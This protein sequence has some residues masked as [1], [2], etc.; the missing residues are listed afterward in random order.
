L[1]GPAGANEAEPS[2]L[3]GLSLQHLA[4][5]IQTAK[6]VRAWREQKEAALQTISRLQE[7]I[8]RAEAEAFEKEDQAMKLEEEA[9]RLEQQGAADEVRSVSGSQC[10]TIGT[11][12]IH[13][14]QLCRR[15]ICCQLNS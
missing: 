2:R 7:D 1:Q 12:S 14:Y 4:N 5:T 6:K 3:D 9:L 8:N 15:Y 10:C 13:R 11:R